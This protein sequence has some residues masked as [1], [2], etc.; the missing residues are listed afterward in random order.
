VLRVILVGLL[1]VSAAGFV[2][3]RT[4]EGAAFLA[5]AEKQLD[6]LLEPTE[7]LVTS[8]MPSIGHR[9]KAA[10]KTPPREAQADGGADGVAR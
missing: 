4:T 7:R 2:A 8:R 10:S 3:S 5:R 9:S 6:Q 1:V